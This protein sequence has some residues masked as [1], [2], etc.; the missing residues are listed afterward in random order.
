MRKSGQKLDLALK[1]FLFLHQYRPRV[2]LF[3]RGS[4]RPAGQV[5]RVD[6][7]QPEKGARIIVAKWRETAEQMRDIW[8][9]RYERVTRHSF[10]LSAGHSAAGSP[11]LRL[12]LQVQKDIPQRNQS[13]AP[14]FL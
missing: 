6:T 9:T 4:Y 11:A 14:A 3:A 1:K 13:L 5:S 7:F 10:I 2:K 8:I 12:S